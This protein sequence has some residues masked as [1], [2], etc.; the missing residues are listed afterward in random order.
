MLVRSM[1]IRVDNL[2]ATREP[3]DLFHIPSIY[4]L[5]VSGVKP[6]GAIPRRRRAILI[7]ELSHGPL[8]PLCVPTFFFF[9]AV[10]VTTRQHCFVI[11]L[12]GAD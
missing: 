7:S 1:Q 6:R 9:S 5:M 10:R 2:R 3:S 4:H 12:R 11:S 8:P